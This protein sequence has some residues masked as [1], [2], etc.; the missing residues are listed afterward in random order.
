MAGKPTAALVLLILGGLLILVGGAVT[1]A[2]GN[3]ANSL[4]RST[5]GTYTVNGQATNK[6]VAAGAV[7]GLVGLDG[8]V[9]LVAGIIVL[10]M[11]LLVFK[12]ASN[13]GRVKAYGI[14]ALI[15]SL[16]S[17]ANGGGFILGF[18]LALIGSILALVYKG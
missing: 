8:A 11:G 16:I 12:S 10:V 5:N 1:I 13:V 3:A 2:L 7:S 18:I 15:F 14:V 9:G 17:L 4:I 6:S